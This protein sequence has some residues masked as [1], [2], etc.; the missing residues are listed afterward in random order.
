MTMTMTMT[1][2]KS[3]VL[4]VLPP[5]HK[6]AD[7]GKV[8]GLARKAFGNVSLSIADLNVQFET[9]SSLELLPANAADAAADGHGHGQAET[10]SSKMA[11]AS[12][13]EPPQQPA[14]DHNHDPWAVQSQN[15]HTHPQGHPRV[16]EIAAQS[17]SATAAP[18][19]VMQHTIHPTPQPSPARSTSVASSKDQTTDDWTPPTRQ[20]A[21][22]VAAAASTL[23]PS[24]PLPDAHPANWRLIVGNLNGTLS[25][26]EILA[27]IVPRGV[28]LTGATFHSPVP[29]GPGKS[30]PL[31]RY[32]K[33]A[34]ADEDDAHACHAWVKQEAEKGGVVYG[35]VAP[36]TKVHVGNLIRPSA[37]VTLQPPPPPLPPVNESVPVV[38]APIA[39]VAD[40]ASVT[41]SRSP[42]NPFAPM[43]RPS[44]TATPTPTSIPRPSS[45]SVNTPDPAASSP[46]PEANPKAAYRVTIGNLLPDLTPSQLLSGILPRGIRPVGLTLAPLQQLVGR[47]DSVRRVLLEFATKDDMDQVHEH[48][49]EQRGRVPDMI[50]PRTKLVV[51]M[52]GVAPAVKVKAPVAPTLAVPG[53]LTHSAPAAAAAAAGSSDFP[54]ASPSAFRLHISNLLPTVDVPQILAAL[55]P[56]KGVTVLG[57]SMF[58]PRPLSGSKR[59]VLVRSLK[60]AFATEM[61]AK[62]CVDWIKKDQTGAVARIVVK[63]AKVTV[64]NPMAPME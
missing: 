47:E 35:M 12:L 15:G 28:L 52:S 44:P 60:L 21:Q 48:V 30:G 6:C 8:L 55:V 38:Q 26:A 22:P 23:V 49:K 14:N 39:V 37:G 51:S 19:V 43:Y 40:Q 18:A 9:V 5:A 59:D 27:T 56:P 61:E 62:K 50:A 24:G 45:V 17:G 57:V 2:L 32:I 36:G 53:P 29:A 3:P 13:Q 7:L 31:V 11:T 1:P 34:F 41:S 64:G 10:C 25:S 16:T 20:P 63:G 46:L 33:L 42:L 54:E 4:V 58:T